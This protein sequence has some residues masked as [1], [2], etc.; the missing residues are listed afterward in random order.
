MS[1]EIPAVLVKD[2][3]YWLDLL[4][5]DRVQRAEIQDR[6]IVQLC[7]GKIPLYTTAVPLSQI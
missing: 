6:V 7:L 4:R 2:A 1:P 5:L 3:M